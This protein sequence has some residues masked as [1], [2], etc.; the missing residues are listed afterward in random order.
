[1][2]LAAGADPD[3]ATEDGVTALHI[4]CESYNLVLADALLA[5]G[6]SVN[7]VTETGISSLR[8]AA[9]FGSKD[10]VERLL[11]CKGVDVNHADQEGTTALT[12]VLCVDKFKKEHFKI[13][14]LLLAHG[15]SLDLQWRGFLSQFRQRS[16]DIG[17][18]SQ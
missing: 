2:L 18:V 6:A 17:M 3:I 14:V 7:A 4:A 9:V 11:C 1:L 15:A 10:L 12:A 16:V 8:I 5:H 13:S